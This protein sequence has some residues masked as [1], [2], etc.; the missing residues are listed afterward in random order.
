MKGLEQEKVA[1]E[2]GAFV[3]E[4]REKK[5]L[6]Q[7]EV[8]DLVGVCRSYYGHIESGIREIYLGKA[9]K[10]CYVLGLSISDFEKFL[11]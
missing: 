8:A 6:S 3:R 4:A 9:L 1:K 7:E 5:G 10:I 11:K 2:F